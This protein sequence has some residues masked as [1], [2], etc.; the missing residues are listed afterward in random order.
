MKISYRYS[1]VDPLHRKYTILLAFLPILNVYA[2]SFMK[3][4]SLGMIVASIF[5][6]FGVVKLFFNIKL[7]SK[8]IIPLSLLMTWIA[9]GSVGFLVPSEIGFDISLY[10]YSVLKLAVW[11]VIIISM[12]SSYFRPDIFVDVLVK[13]AIFSTSYL[14]FQAFMTYIL[15]LSI[16]NGF[17]LG[18][19]SANYTDYYYEQDLNAGQIRLA[20]VWFEP[21]QYAAYIILACICI[22]FK[23]D[24]LIENRL[25]KFSFLSFGLILSTSSAAIFWLFIII[26]TWAVWR[27]YVGVIFLVIF[28]SAIFYFSLNAEELLNQLRMQGVLGYSIYLAITKIEHWEDSARLGASFKTAFAIL[29][30]GAYKF[31]GIG[32]G[33]ENILMNKLGLELLYLNSFSRIFIWSGFIGVSLYLFFYLYSVFIFRE[34]KLSVL[35]LT[36]CFI[37]GFYSTM[38][39]SPES[40]LYYSMAFYSGR[41]R[42]A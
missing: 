34:N 35:L 33:S 39:T 2:F 32:I 3:G 22:L 38:W 14:I 17:D 16:S 23:N 21:A 6:V 42:I 25:L 11:G 36:Y 8:A 9:F 26:T 7:Y 31:S 19:I 20:S 15:G 1:N 28:F 41:C 29:E 37:S 18:I 24:Q 40:I 27:K 12:S 30:Y 4:L 10:I 5:A 13:V